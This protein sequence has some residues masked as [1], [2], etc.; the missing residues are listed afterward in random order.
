MAA[1]NVTEQFHGGANI[2]NHDVPLDKT[3]L[4]VGQWSLILPSGVEDPDELPPI[5]GGRRVTGDDRKD[6]FL[7]IDANPRTQDLTKEEIVELS[8]RIEAGVTASILLALTNPESQEEALWHLTSVEVARLR[9]TR[10]SRKDMDADWL[11]DAAKVQPQVEEYLA[12]AK[13]IVQDMGKH[14]VTELNLLVND[15]KDAENHLVEAHVR[16]AIK[17]AGRSKYGGRGLSPIELIQLANTGLV[18]AMQKFDYTQGYAFT[19]YSTAWIEQRIKR[20]FPGARLVGLPEWLYDTLRQLH[21]AK[22]ELRAKYN[23]PPTHKELA[24]K[25]N[26]SEEK[27]LELQLYNTDRPLSL[28][29]PVGTE[30]GSDQL[31]NFVADTSS[32]SVEDETMYTELKAIIEHILTTQATPDEAEI[33]RQRYGLDGGGMEDFKEIGKTLHIHTKVVQRLCEQARRKIA[34]PHNRHLFK[35]YLHGVEW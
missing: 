1:E 15:G 18:H 30:A 14:A 3:G 23:R 11:T 27:I 24:A 31:G 9:P 32:L 20:A 21:N 6:Y 35:G 19:T 25:L 13:E 29:M 5:L 4:E 16:W 10:R 7:D 22:E 12:W 34:A 17:V 33:F 26:V 8:K 28:D 2:H